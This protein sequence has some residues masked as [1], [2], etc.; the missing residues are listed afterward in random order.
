[1]SAIPL[2]EFTHLLSACRPP[3]G[4]GNFIIVALS[5]GPDSICL[6]SLLKRAS[7]DVPLRSITID[8]GL[9]PTSRDSALRTRTRSEAI[10]VPGEIL[11]AEWD[12]GKPSQGE[13]LEEAARDARYRALWRSLQTHG[14]GGGGPC[15]VMFGHHADDQLETVIM[16]VLRGTGTYGLGGMRAV[17]RWGWT[18][19][20]G[21]RH[22]QTHTSESKADHVLRDMQ[23]YITRPLL[24]IPKERILATCRARNLEYEQDVTNF[25]PDLTVRNAVRHA[26][27]RTHDSIS[28]N[29]IYISSLA[30]K[31]PISVFTAG[32]PESSSISAHKTPTSLPAD[33]IRASVSTGGIQAA[34]S[35][36]HTL[37]GG[38]GAP[39]LE[40]MRA[41]VGKMSARVREVDEIV[42]DY[43]RTHTRPSPPST[44]LLVPWL[45][46]QMERDV[47]HA[48]VH[49]ILRYVSPHPWGTPESE[50]HRRTTS[51]E[52]II[53]RVFYEKDNPVSFCAGAHVLWSPVWARTDGKI[54]TRQTRDERKGKVR[55]WL[56]SRQPP[57][58]STSL[59]RQVSPGEKLIVW[60]NRFLIRVPESDDHSRLFVRPRGR[61]VLPRLVRNDHVVD[62]CGVEFVRGLGAI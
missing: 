59:E 19:L 10:G 25:M 34:I 3:T 61:L 1:M 39:N 22:L 24:T 46:G 60:D 15:T 40:L 26:L 58:R 18:D 29:R 50:A 16:R 27:S 21:R 14:I 20:D 9:Q 17:R 42:T 49:R 54:R 56:A 38:T 62:D 41:Y 55:A 47:A 32:I 30:N 6:L 2:A 12:R 51:I 35:H 7:L 57:S 44:L 13:A 8:H 45:G 37:A 4:W 33:G 28:T 11:P 53:Q 43:L 31:T 23:T 36:V 52:R 5:G 48:L